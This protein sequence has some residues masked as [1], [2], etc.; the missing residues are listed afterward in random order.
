MLHALVAQG[1]CTSIPVAGVALQGCRLLPLLKALSHPGHRHV[2]EAVADSCVHR[3]VLQSG[4][5]EMEAG[6]TAISLKAQ[7]TLPWAPCPPPFRGSCPSAPI[8]KETEGPE[9][10]GIDQVPVV[11]KCRSQS[12][13]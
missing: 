8:G 4:H 1:Y 12:Q 10:Q 2:R 7:E 3:D 6:W 5:W 13:S 9:A 11:W